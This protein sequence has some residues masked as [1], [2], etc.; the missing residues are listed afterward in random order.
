[1]EDLKR[2]EENKFPTPPLRCAAWIW[3]KF[4]ICGSFA[5]LRALVMHTSSCG[6]LLV[7]ASFEE[8]LLQMDRRVTAL[9][10]VLFD[11]FIS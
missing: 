3:G 10:L 8:D 11:Y 2:P 6:A 9:D 7:M 4:A 5:V 1:V